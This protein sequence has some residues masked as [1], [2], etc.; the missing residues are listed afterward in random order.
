MRNYAHYYE[1]TD[2]DYEVFEREL[3]AAVEN[4]GG[5]FYVQSEQDTV[6]EIVEEIRSHEAMAVDDI[7]TEQKTDLPIPG[8]I[9]LLISLAGSM[10]CVTFLKGK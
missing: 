7:V 2:A 3:R 10:I 4:T 6:S 1:Y 5:E 8:I 9:A